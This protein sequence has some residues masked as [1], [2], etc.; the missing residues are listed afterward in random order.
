MRRV[1]MMG[2]VASALVLGAAQLLTPV[3]QASGG[4]CSCPK[5]TPVCCL[6]CNGTFGFCSRSHAFCP[7]CPAP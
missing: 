4:V 3:A 5:N 2:L 6:N 1:L 7:E